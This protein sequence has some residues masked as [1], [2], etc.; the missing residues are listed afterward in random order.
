MTSEVSAKGL[1]SSLGGG[2]SRLHLSVVIPWA[3][4][5]LLSLSNTSSLLSERFHNAAYGVLSNVL[6]IAGPAIADAMLSRSP[7]KARARAVDSATRQLQ[8]ERADLLNKNRALHAENEAVRASKAALAKEH[9][10][11]RAVS[12][13]RAAAVRAVA[14]RTSSVLAARSAEA[15]STLPLRAAPYIGIAA[16]VGFTTMELKSDCELAKALADLNAEHG[17]EP[18]D[19]GQVCKVVESVP[20]PSQAWNSVKA[21]SSATLN[22]TYDLLESTANQFGFT[23]QAGA[24][25]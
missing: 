7:T 6:G 18:V 23:L 10:A 4:V 19:S 5:F 14:T 13:K 15:V 9:H 25:P 21:R 8:G 24:R 3:L 20:T 2:A 11:L 12:A 16:L 17:N 22:S 1:E